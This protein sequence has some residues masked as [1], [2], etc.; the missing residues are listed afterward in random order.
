MTAICPQNAPFSTPRICPFLT[1]FITSYPC[2]VFHAGSKEKKP[3]TWFDTPFDKALILF[4]N[5]IQVLDLP[6][7]TGVG[8]DSFRL[9]FLEG[10]W[11][12]D[13]F[14]VI[15]HTRGGGMRRSQRFREK[16]LR[17]FCIACWTQD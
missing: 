1:L 14:I 10:L 16:A 13:I 8:N 15:D 2:N 9:Q 6:Q 5:V 12:G 7:F 11:I 17:R 4:N 3:R